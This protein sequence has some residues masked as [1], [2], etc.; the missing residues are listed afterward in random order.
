MPLSITERCEVARVVTS[1]DFEI[2]E[3]HIAQFKGH[4]VEHGHFGSVIY[5]N[6][7]FEDDDSRSQALALV[8]W[9]CKYVKSNPLAIMGSGSYVLREMAGYVSE[10]NVAA[11]EQLIH[12]LKEQTD[13]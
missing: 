11:L 13:G 1:Q 4:D 3:D 10:C 8:E 6:P 5:W 2:I 9:I 7:D 12:E